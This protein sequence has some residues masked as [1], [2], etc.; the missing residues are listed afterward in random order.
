M[1]PFQDS[2]QASQEALSFGEL[3]T[4][5]YEPGSNWLLQKPSQCCIEYD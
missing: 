4:R 1:D 5:I 2:I 3:S